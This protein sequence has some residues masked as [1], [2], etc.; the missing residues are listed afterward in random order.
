[1]FINMYSKYVHDHP[2][3]CIKDF[4]SVKL[5]RIFFQTAWFTCIRINVESP[6]GIH[7]E[8]VCQYRVDPAVCISSSDSQD[9]HPG[10]SELG[11]V[12][13]GKK[14]N[15][16]GLVNAIRYLLSYNLCKVTEKSMSRRCLYL[17]TLLREHRMVVIFIF[18]IN[19]QDGLS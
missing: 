15:H 11:N 17:V 18:H 9:L 16:K 12:S 5:L 2:G 4:L 14:S 8:V 13:L 6:G 7:D 10:T 1:M 19:I 3:T